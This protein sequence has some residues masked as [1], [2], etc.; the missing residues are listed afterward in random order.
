MLYVIWTLNIVNGNQHFGYILQSHKH[1]HSYY[2]TDNADT[3]TPCPM[4]T[5]DFDCMA[6]VSLV[7]RSEAVCYK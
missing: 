7:T 5:S 3:S 2:S 6:K 1:D 4:D